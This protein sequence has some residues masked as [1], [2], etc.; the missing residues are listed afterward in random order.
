[1]QGSIVYEDGGEWKYS[2]MGI[3]AKDVSDALAGVVFKIATNYKGIP[4]NI[5]NDDVVVET[6]DSESNSIYS[7]IY[8]QTKLKVFA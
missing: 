5:W 4:P 8:N 6:A 7:H 2:Q 3:N 1:M